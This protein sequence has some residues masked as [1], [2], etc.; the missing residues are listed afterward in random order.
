MRCSLLNYRP[1]LYSIGAR[2]LDRRRRIRQ[3]RGPA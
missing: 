2:L 1:L 3:R